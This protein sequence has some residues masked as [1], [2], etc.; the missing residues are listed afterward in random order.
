MAFSRQKSH[1]SASRQTSAFRSKSRQPQRFS[2]TTE[3]HS[4]RTQI[5]AFAANHGDRSESPQPQNVIPLACSRTS[6]RRTCVARRTHSHDSE[7]PQNRI[8]LSGLSGH[9]DSGL[10][11][12]HRSHTAPVCWHSATQCDAVRAVL[13]E[14][15]RCDAAAVFR[16]G[17]AYADNLATRIS[18]RDYM[19]HP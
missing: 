2:A 15:D 19:T 10:T 4:S 6:N 9:A 3:S 16:R 7:Q 17:I 14:R 5:T 13:C 8:P 11:H 12:A 18:H 1:S